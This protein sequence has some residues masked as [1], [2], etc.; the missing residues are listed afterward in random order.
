M[1]PLPKVWL[2]IYPETWKGLQV[3]LSAALRKAVEA[4]ACAQVTIYFHTATH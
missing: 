2:L 4:L 3:I 1:S